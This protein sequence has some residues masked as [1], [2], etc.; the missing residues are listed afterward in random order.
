MGDVKKPVGAYVHKPG[1]DYGP[2]EE[3]GESTPDVG[4]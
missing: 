2:S 4:P 3:E 1:V